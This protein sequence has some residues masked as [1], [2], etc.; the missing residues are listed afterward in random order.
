[1]MKYIVVMLCLVIQNFAYANQAIINMP[2]S[3]KSQ[4]VIERLKDDIRHV[5]EKIA[6]LESKNI[7]SLAEFS[8]KLVLAEHYQVRLGLVLEFNNNSNAFQVLSVSPNSLAANAGIKVDDKIFSV[9]FERVD[10]DNSD[11][12]IQSLQQLEVEE[13]LILTAS[14]SGKKQELTIPVIGIF[15]PKVDIQFGCCI[16]Q[17]KS[18]V[19]QHKQVKPNVNYTARTKQLINKLALKIQS[20]VA[21]IAEYEKEE[22]KSDNN[23]NYRIFIP[24][25]NRS[26]LGLS[27][28]IDNI[29]QG[30]V[31]QSVE[32]GSVAEQVN[33]VPNDI[34]VEVNNL[35]ANEENKQEIINKLQSLKS[36]DNILLSI[37]QHGETKKLSLEIQEQ[38][39]PEVNINVG[40]F[41]NQQ[42]YLQALLGDESKI[43]APFRGEN[44]LSTLTINYRSLDQLLALAVFDMGRSDRSK[45]KVV[46]ASMG[47]RLRSTQRRL[48]SL[49]GNRFYFEAF[50]TPLNR[51]VLH[52]IKTDLELL[53]NSTA[54]Y[55]FSKKEQLAYWLNLYNVTL[56]DEL[57]AIYPKKNLASLFEGDNALVNRK[58]LKVNNVSLSL[59]DIKNVILKEKYHHD[60]DILYGLYQGVIGGPNIREQAYTGEN[61]YNALAKNAEEFVNSNRGTYRKNNSTF[62]ISS[63]YAKNASY[64]PNFQE[65][66][67]AHILKHLEGYYRSQLL[68]ASEVKATISNWHINDVYGTIRNF[69]GGNNTNSAAL[70]GAVNNRYVNI[71]LD[72]AALNGQLG[73][74]SPQGQQLIEQLYDKHIQTTSYVTVTDLESN[75]AKTTQNKKTAACLTK[76]CKQLFESFDVLAKR[77]QWAS[78]YVSLLHFNGV[79][80]KQSTE[81]AL[82]RL[83]KV[84]NRDWKTFK[85]YYSE[86]QN[87]YA[88]TYYQ[89]GYIYL[90]ED[91]YRDVNKAISN[92]T[93]ASE[94][95]DFKAALLLGLIYL[96]DDYQT[97]NSNLAKHWLGQ[98]VSEMPQS[99]NFLLSSYG[100]DSSFPNKGFDWQIEQ[101]KQTLAEQEV[102]NAELTELFSSQK[103]IENMQAIL[104]KI[105]SARRRGRR[106]GGK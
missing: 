73:L 8:Y 76:K 93:K 38:H 21:A 106:S 72:N 95:G 46:R 53:P 26:N 86:S 33:I 83:N 32:H 36:G 17:N 37:Q 15:V 41:S 57:V 80:T 84:L 85:F 71:V 34:I 3:S 10:S 35:W 91:R 2:L 47:T 30:I 11:K 81:R 102:M 89:L 104:P 5:M 70:L 48:T 4:L 88:K 94:F 67:T 98:S 97:Q 6:L 68:G 31:V 63:L 75:S 103:N 99:Y 74:V 62:L 96:T 49:E 18:K 9:N 39:F 65:D 24:A 20:T 16:S 69:G 45:A 13:E 51:Q 40:S 14:I 55:K 22:G 19:T 1:M 66:V 82:F 105:R 52:K 90:I 44:N 56:L 92:L 7:A 23:I 79:G 78:Y 27:I 100:I 61:V 50:K 42:N 64:F 12:I 29:S 58:I 77:D 101:L 87:I 28:N 43:P 59:N 60:P 25:T 54:L